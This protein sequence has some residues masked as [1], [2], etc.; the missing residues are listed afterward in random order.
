METAGEC[1]DK[2]RK[3]KIMVMKIE[4]LIEKRND[5]VDVLVE[6]MQMERMEAE[7][8]VNKYINRCFLKNESEGSNSSPSAILYVDE[9]GG[10]W[11]RVNVYGYDFMLD[12]YDMKDGEKDEFTF[13]EAIEFA[14]S[15]GC[16]IPSKDQWHIVGAYKKEIARVIEE[17]G[18][19]QLKGWLWSK[20]EY[21]SSTLGWF[22]NGPF[23]ILGTISKCTTYGSRRLAYPKSNS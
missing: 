3:E 9:K 1:E 8:R 10:K 20:T 18:G 14:K 15:Q 2:I 23:G 19:D 17:A 11:V 6:I 13:D 22:F 7:M 12:I 16:E 5:A 21:S 4:E